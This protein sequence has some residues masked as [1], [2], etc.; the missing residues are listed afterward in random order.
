MIRFTTGVVVGVVLAVMAAAGVVRLTRLDA[1]VAPG[2]LESRMMAWLRTF[3]VPED[4]AAR[5][6]P[7]ALTPEV[8]RD[9]R[10]HYAD[11]CAVCHGAD[12]RGDTPM[13]RGFA[14]RP[15]DLRAAATQGQRDGVL[16]QAIERGVRFTGMPAFTTGTPEGEAAS[17]AL[18]H[19]IRSMPR[20]TAAEVGEVRAAMPRSPDDV[21]RELAEE[22][23]L[24]GGQ[25]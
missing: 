12:G 25:P 24:E 17:W 14:P 11:H 7:V 15:P 6:N 9:A 5:P 13:G 3:S 1:S 10:A 8:L 16:F 21:R 22:R 4:V 2:W 19:L 18:V 23:F 20:W